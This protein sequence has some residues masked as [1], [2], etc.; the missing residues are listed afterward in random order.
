MLCIR[1]L[2]FC[3]RTDEKVSIPANVSIENEY[4]RTYRRA[5]VPFTSGIRSCP[6]L[7]TNRRCVP[8]YAS[9]R[10]KTSYISTSASPPTPPAPASPAVFRR[11]EREGKRD[12]WWPRR[13]EMA[14]QGIVPPPRK[15]QICSII[16][17]YLSSENWVPSLV[18]PH[19]R[20]AIRAHKFYI[21][22]PPLP[23]APRPPTV[24]AACSLGNLTRAKKQNFLQSTPKSGETP[25]HSRHRWPWERIL[26]YC[27]HWYKCTV[28]GR[29]HIYIQTHAHTS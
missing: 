15:K 21:Q 26:R 6:A 25:G 14:K 24:R 20:P 23:G 9:L 13:A 29:V 8:H 12:T 18:H 10:P 3:R 27:T 7:V 22:P 11:L 17:V 28:K 5:F 4:Y 2:G 16:S 1:A 19:S